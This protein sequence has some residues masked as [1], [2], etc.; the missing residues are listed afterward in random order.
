MEKLGEAKPMN[1]IPKA[2]KR[3]ARAAKRL[4]HRKN[5]IAETKTTRKPGISR[6]NSRSPRCKSLMAKV[7]LKKLLKVAS[8]ILWENPKT[9]IAAKKS[10]KSRGK[11]TN[12]F[13]IR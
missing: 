10:C 3:L 4:E 2:H 12:L 8:T 9:N 6:G 13:L 5:K 11:L 1:N 7:S